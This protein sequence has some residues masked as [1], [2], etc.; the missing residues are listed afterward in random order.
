MKEGGRSRVEQ[1]EALAAAGRIGDGYRL[2]SDPAATGDADALVA[3]ASWRLSGALIRR[4]LSEA[5]KLF[6]LAGDLGHE[7][8]A[9]I[10]I[11]M[12]ANG[13]GAGRHWHDALTRLDR[14]ATRIA[15]ARRERDVIAAMDLDA[16]GAPLMKPQGEPLSTSPH[17]ALFRGFLTEAECR[18]LIDT[19]TPLLRPSVV[20]DPRTGQLILDPVRTSA[21][22]AFPFVLESPAIH[23]INR[24]IAAA[25][26]TAVAQGEPLQVLRYRPGEEY[27]PH[28]DALPGTANQR[29][30]TFLIY[31]N[32]DYDGGETVFVSSRLKV[33]GRA[34]D[35]ILFR[36][37]DMGGKPDMAAR[38]AGLP[39]ARGEKFLLS[40]WIRAASLDLTGP[41]GR[42]F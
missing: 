28:S 42:P 14:R 27:K 20:V 3:L 21:A 6:G 15:A 24:R 39:V 2:L 37:V 22:A 10:H 40:R 8:A 26:G 12:L 16:D 4:D 31:L 17:V 18:Y 33:R 5:R 29:I 38:H 19:A 11:A 1:A 32:D 25:S 7:E 30:L 41:P 34:G 36:N 35:G 23:A 13:A 9:A